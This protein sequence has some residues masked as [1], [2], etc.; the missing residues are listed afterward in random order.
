[1]NSPVDI[2]PDHLEIVRDILSE[3]LPVDVRVWVFGSR[4]NWT[5]KD[6][7]DLDLAMEGAARLDH[8]VMGALEM[9]FEES[10]LPYVVDVVD[11][12]AVGHAFKQIVV[13][14]RAPLPLDG[15]GAKVATAEDWRDSIYGS[16]RAD[17]LESLLED[18]CEEGRGIQ[19]GPFGSQLHQRDYVA[20]GTPIITVEHLGNNRITSQDIPNVSEHDRDRLSKYIIREGDIIFSRVGS[21]DRRAIVRRTEEGWLFSG[22]CLRVRPNQNRIDPAYLSYFFGMPAFQEYIR[23]IAVGAT[24]PSLNTKILKEVPIL[25]PTLS[26][27]R[28]IADVLGTL[29]DK[30]QLNRRMNETLEEMARALFK[31]WFVDFE[32]VR[33]KMEG[34]WRRGESPPGLPA[35]LYELFPERLVPSELG[36]I[37]E[38]WE[39]RRLGE[40]VVAV[41][42][43]TPS[44]KKSEYWNHGKHCWVTPKDL[45]GLSV[46]VLLDTE[47]KITDAGLN[48]IGS[49]LLPPGSILLSSRAPIG[50]LAINEIPVAINQGFIGMRP[51]G[52]IPNLFVL[53]WLETFNEAIINYANGSTFLEISKRNF[54]EIPLAL[55]SE[56]E[57]AEFDKRV[58]LLHEHIV[59]NER[60]SQALAAQRDALLPGLVSGEVKVGAD[61]HSAKRI[62][63]SRNT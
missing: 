44:T 43:T 51:N 60:E 37:P 28:A 48:K 47:R 36:E 24:M 29:D 63:R 11:L 55:S 17:Y 46:P 13:E 40:V 31:S 54:R 61:S 21:V 38:G 9:A 7:S 16:F 3:H 25:Y 4:A 1:M 57:L 18:L 5:T 6:S 10:D 52:G 35:E 59:S 30:I 62:S 42:G 58:R 53:Y 27:Q 15:V 49:G 34:R 8:K 2:R 14:Q 33:A 41:G 19:T 50:Y 45:A 56:A 32:P 26:E 20:N 39:V 22:R 12:N 23:S